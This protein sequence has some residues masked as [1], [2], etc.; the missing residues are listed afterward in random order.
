MRVSITLNSR[1]VTCHIIQVYINCCFIFLTLTNFNL[2]YTLTETS[3]VYTSKCDAIV[4]P[5]IN[6]G[7]PDQVTI[8]ILKE[9]GLMGTLK[10]PETWDEDEVHNHLIKCCYL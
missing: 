10:V 8:K 6:D 9:C 1:N 5:G 4:L 2:L 3:K 7:L